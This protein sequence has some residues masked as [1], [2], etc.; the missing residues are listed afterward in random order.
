MKK[1]RGQFVTKLGVIAATVG[2]AVGL[3]NIWRFPYEAG[4]NGGGAFLVVYL[5]CVFVIGVPAMIAEFSIGRASHSN[6]RNAFRALK[7]GGRYHYV[8]YLGIL[9]AVLILSFYSVVAGWIVE[10][11]YQAAAGGLSGLSAGELARAFGEFTADPVRSVLWTLLFLAVNHIVT[12][13]GVERGI[14]RVSNV[15][16]PLLFL[17][18]IALC[19]K[20][21][22]LSRATEGLNFLF[23]ADFSKLT[24][25]VVLGAMGQAFF[26]LSLGAT[27]LMTYASYFSD[28]TPLVRSATVIAALDT[29]VALLAGIIIF[30]A[31]F[32][33]GLEPTAGPKLVFETLPA[34]F[35]QMPGGSLWLVAF[36]ALLF[37]ASLTSTISMSE[38]AISF[39]S[40][41]RGLSRGAAT[42]VTTGVAMALG[43]V[44]ALS[45]GVLGGL[46]IFGL[47]VFELF[48]FVASNI[49]L[50]IGG[51][52][53]SL[54]VGWVV[55][56][57]IVDAQLTNF[58]Q[59]RITLAAPIRF[60][61]RFVAPVCIALIFL[62]GLGLLGFVAG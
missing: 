49:I 29:V 9:G 18:L 59:R 21:L 17:I 53:C 51:M 16:M 8:A 3:G 24:P 26:S 38:T 41:E 35:L 37:F 45:F 33:F 50:P 1:G 25:G 5:L 54:F 22:T 47:T 40:E 20:S 13:R 12:S 30:P 58:G 28:S 15:L 14:E 11:L 61:M 27:V 23:N 7:P 2:S 6:A 32:S 52:G 34:V 48:D 10:Y 4:V 31:V 42:G 43:A 39:L 44:C 57:K 36:F 56:R 60:C 62:Y 46:K 55:D 19:V